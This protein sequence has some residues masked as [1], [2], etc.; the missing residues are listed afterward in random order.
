MSSA[1]AATAECTTCQTQALDVLTREGNVFLTGAAGT[2]K[3]WLLERYL[4]GKPS[5]AFPIVASTGAAAVLVGGRTFH[6]FFGLGIMEGGLEA[7]VLRARKSRKLGLRLQMASC[8]VI[9]EVS[10]LS[11]VTL[12]CAE[13]IAREVRGSGEPWGGLRIIAVGDFAQLPPVTAG[14]QLKDWAFTHDVWTRSDFQP[15]LLSTVMRTQDIAFL[16]ILNAVRLGTVTPAV[17]SFLESRTGLHDELQEG[18]RLYPHRA[19]ADAHNHWRLQQLDGPLHSLPTRYEGAERAMDS[20]KRA[21]PIPDVLHLKRGAL[22]MLRKNDVSGEQRYVNGSLGRV[23]GVDE[24]TLRIGLFTGEDI[25]VGREK[26]SYLDGDGQEL[27]GAWNFPVTLA[28]ATTIHKAQG[29]S[30]DKMIVD[31][32]A[33]WEPGQAYVALSRV[34]S[35][36]GLYIERWT[37]SSIKAEPLVSSFY[38]GLAEKAQKYVPRPHFVSRP[39]YQKPK[40]SDDDT[41]ASRGPSLGRLKRAAMI[42]SLV[43]QQTRLPEMAEAAGVKQE[44]VILYLE[45]FIEEGESVEIGYLLQDIPDAPAIREKFLELGTALLRPAFDAFNGAHSFTTLRV[46]RCVMQATT[47]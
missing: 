29:A 27:V 4:H 28:W 18:T 16:D 24:E 26:F 1:P 9:D 38:D 46:V 36:E 13:R 43:Q 20:A 31:L 11:G 3:S 14:N 12:A 34:R 30:L 44:R 10:M 6:S 15:A 33:L 35:A 2:G 5:A 47:A 39:I 40:E 8:V 41:V 25:E 32:S 42:K 37:E 23:I 22:V 45:K 7:T 19:K 17:R 21:I